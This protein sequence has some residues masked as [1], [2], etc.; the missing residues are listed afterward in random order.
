[1]A[2]RNPRRGLAPLKNNY[3]FVYRRI[4]RSPDFRDGTDR[5]I[6][7]DLL[8]SA[9]WE[10]REV[11][12]GGLKV[13]EPVGSV[14]V[15]RRKIHEHLGDWCH[16][17]PL[18]VFRR[19]ERLERRG[20]VK[21]TRSHLGTLVEI[22]K[23]DKYQTGS[24][25]ANHPQGVKNQEVKGEKRGATNQVVHEP[26]NEPP[27]PPGSSR[28]NEPPTKT[29]TADGKRG[30]SVVHEPPN[31]PP[32][33][34]GSSRENEPHS[35][36]KNKKNTTN[37]KPNCRLSPSARAKQK[38]G[39]TDRPEGWEE[40]E[41]RQACRQIEEEAERMGH[42]GLNMRKEWQRT[43]VRAA[44]RGEYPC[45][46]LEG[47]PDRPAY[48]PGQIFDAV[49]WFYAE[50]HRHNEADPYRRV[51]LY[52]IGFAIGVNWRTGEDALAEMLGKIEQANSPGSGRKRGFPTSRELDIE[53]ELEKAEIKLEQRK[54]TL[55]DRVDLPAED[56]ARSLVLRET[57]FSDE[58]WSRWDLRRTEIEV[59]LGRRNEEDL[60]E[61]RVFFTDR[62]GHDPREGK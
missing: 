56:H 19:L 4:K 26:P 14:F 6:F 25:G 46:R 24:E 53:E 59:E 54:T 29:A 13:I 7:E 1:M 60:A 58:E 36:R 9:A 42:H 10:D 30:F 17:S 5:L 2:E 20:M 21:L 31:E 15:S 23:W 55:K 22:V 47:W 34:P 32:E 45:P 43:L 50:P 27:E 52:Q 33:P 38:P 8:L 51:Y 39:Q 3:L 62:F 18:A 11:K 12:I 16:L 35:L 61:A 41:V 40:E 48:S 37:L 57:L 28:E 44:L 49:R